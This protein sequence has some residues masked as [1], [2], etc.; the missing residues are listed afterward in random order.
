MSIIKD[1][2][3]SRPEIS[4]S[5]LGWLEKYWLPQSFVIDLEAAYRFGNLLDAMIT[6]PE[7]INHFNYTLSGEQFTQEEFKKAADMKK[8]FMA[9]PFCKA[10]AAQSE[11]QKVIIEKDWII[12]YNGITIC[13]DMRCKYDFFRSDIDIA[14]DLKSTACTTQKA[15]EQ[16]I[17]HF[18]YDR[19]GA[20]YMDLGKKNNFIFIGVSKVEPHK[21]FKVPVK[22]GDALYNSGKAKYHELAFKYSYLFGE[23]TSAA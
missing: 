5:E 14:A 8:A 16:S 6:E 17:Y 20:L 12:E 15:F 1:P 4:N 19:Q 2:Y 9:D 22:R 23:I 10:L 21:I 3:Y 18:N 11:M 7:F 13:I